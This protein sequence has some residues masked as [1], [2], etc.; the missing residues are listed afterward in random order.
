MGKDKNSKNQKNGLV[1]Q[2]VNSTSENPSSQSMLTGLCLLQ[3][4]KWVPQSDCDLPTS[5]SDL[6][7]DDIT[8]FGIDVYKYVRVSH[9][10]F[11]CRPSSS[12]KNS[13]LGATLS[14]KMTTEYIVPHPHPG[15]TCPFLY[16]PTNNNRLLSTNRPR[17]SKSMPTCERF[18]RMVDLSQIDSPTWSLEVSRELLDQPVLKGLFLTLLPQ[19]LYHRF[20]HPRAT[21]RTFDWTF[22]PGWF[23]KLSSL[24]IV[25]RNSCLVCLVSSFSLMYF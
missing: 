12:I 22:G 7:I 17:P 21:A 20:W 8:Q 6:G 25:F 24:A 2:L 11:N 18:K 4:W 15:N 1:A 23:S 10:I 13:L 3:G 9:F 16:T 14:F 19:C 5:S